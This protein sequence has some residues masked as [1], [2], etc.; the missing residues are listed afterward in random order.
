MIRNLL[1]MWRSNLK[2]S[3][4]KRYRG[5]KPILEYLEDRVVPVT[6]VASWG[7]D[8]QHTAVSSVASQPL[9]AIH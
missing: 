7:G 2:P 5:F 6:P 1:R 3:Q 4:P 8:A 9:S